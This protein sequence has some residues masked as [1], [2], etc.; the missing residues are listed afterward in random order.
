MRNF[1]A[2]KYPHSDIFS[3]KY[4]VTL[5]FGSAV[6]FSS[7][8]VSRE[9]FDMGFYLCEVTLSTGAWCT[10]CGQVQQKSDEEQA[11]VHIP[12]AKREDSG[13]YAITVTNPFGEDTGLVSVVVLGMPVLSLSLSLSLSLVRFVR[14]RLYNRLDETF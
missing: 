4:C 14:S 9:K 6:F 1:L 11:Q 3:R 13:K 12:V 2:E 10:G 7:E 5:F 8:P